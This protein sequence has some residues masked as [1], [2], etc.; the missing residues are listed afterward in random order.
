MQRNEGETDEMNIVVQ[1]YGGSSLATPQR[2][3]AIA[4]RIV[5]TKRSGASVV[6]VVSAMGDTTDDL[7]ALARQLGGEAP[8]R[9]E[10]DMLLSTG[11]QVSCALLAMAIHTLGEPVISLTGPQVGI[12]TDDTHMKAKILQIDSTR[13]QKELSEGKIAIVAGFQGLSRENSEITTLGRGGS[14]TTAVALAAAL[15]AQVCEIYTDVDGVFTADPRVVPNARLLRDIS[16]GEMLELASLGAL[17]LQPRSVEMAAHYGVTI[18]VRS[19]FTTQPGTYVR[20][21]KEVERDMVVVG[22]AHDTNVAKV[23]VTDVPDKPGV[24]GQLFAALAAEQI[25]VDM[26]VQSTKQE[27]TTDMLFTVTR[28]DLAKTLEVAGRVAQQ[29]G[30]TGVLHTLDLGKVSIVGAGM[31]SN[32]G[33]AARMFEALAA[34]GINIDA[35]STS[36]IK[37]SCLVKLDAVPEAVRAMHEAFNLGQTKLDTERAATFM[38]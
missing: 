29:L 37:V 10:M 19:S 2:V 23:V 25:N 36:E 8:P 31:M 30:A 20:G 26:I 18:H 13:V 32:P 17:V 3:K 5:Q 24:A 33:V 35:I 9:R 1:K 16:Y 28:D 6:A 15:G 21:Q 27:N 12:I 14:D 11:E 4:D 7:I 22:V 34:R 38:P